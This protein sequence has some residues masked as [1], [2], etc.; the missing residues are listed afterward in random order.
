M[1]NILEL[2][3]ALQQNLPRNH[4]IGV[5]AANQL[6]PSI[7][8]FTAAIII[9][10]APSNKP[11]EHWVAVYISNSGHGEYFNSYGL[12]PYIPY[13]IRFLKRNCLFYTW[14]NRCIQGDLSQFCGHYSFLYL[15]C[16]ASG[17]SLQD[18]LNKFSTGNI[19]V[20]DIMLY[21]FMRMV[22]GVRLSSP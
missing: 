1:L 5:Y 6:P 21:S 19:N 4:F 9:N 3:V 12:P 13:H 11:G 22:P 14:N 20:S 2:Y 10:T 7:H 18:F 8:T 16:R 15:A 17:Y